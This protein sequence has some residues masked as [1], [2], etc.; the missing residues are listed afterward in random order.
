MSDHDPVAAWFSRRRL[1][2]FL[3]FGLYALDGWHEQ[4]QMRRRRRRHEYGQLAARFNPCKFDPEAILD[5]AGE[6]GMEYVCLTA[7]HH[8]GFCLWPSA[9]SDFTVAA[10]PYGRDIVGALAAACQRRGMAFGLYYSVVDWRHPNY[11][12]QGRHHELV[13]PEAGDRPDGD[14]YLAYLKA[15]VRELCTNYGRISHFFWD[16]NVPEWR[17]PSINAMIRSLQPEVVINDRGFDPGDF[18]TPEREYQSDTL[19]ARAPFARPTEACN[20][21]GAQSWGYRRDE[22]YYS[23]RHLL[24]SIDTVFCRGGNYLL[25]VGPDGEGAIPAPAARLLRGVG[26]WL[27]KARPAFDG[28]QLAA[29]GCDNPGVLLTRRG[30]TLYA[31]LAKQPATTAVALAPIVSTPTRATLL[32]SGRP[33]RA[34]ADLLPAHWQDGQRY[35]VL[36]DLP[37]DEL[38]NQV[39]VVEL[40]FA[41]SPVLAV[42]VPAAT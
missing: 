13:G 6:A 14:A 18:G 26:A 29:E 16:M 32:D 23:L 21:V 40:V 7:K 41:E 27:A 39:P 5:L 34:H 4:E 24:E 35:L 42:P 28:C 20:S 12:N 3:H 38:A 15:Q 33:V 37:V 19:G 22:D 8:D 31:H 17:D 11:P 30:N 9:H 10:T 36:A 25:N 2:L 1:G